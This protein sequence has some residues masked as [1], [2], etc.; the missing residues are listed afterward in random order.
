MEIGTETSV[1]QDYV[2]GKMLEILT[3]V[4]FKF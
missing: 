2:P 4:H 1:G 3:L